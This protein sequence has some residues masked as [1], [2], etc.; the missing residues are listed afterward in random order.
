MCLPEKEGVSA[1][2]ETPSWFIGRGDGYL[3]TPSS[4]PTLVNAAIAL[5]S[6]ADTKRNTEQLI[7]L[8]QCA[9]EA[10]V[11]DISAVVI[12]HRI[13]VGGRDGKSVAM[14]AG[15]RDVDKAALA[16]KIVIGTL[17][18]GGDIVG[19]LYAVVP[20]QLGERVVETAP[21]GEASRREGHNAPVGQGGTHHKRVGFDTGKPQASGQ[22]VAR[23]QVSYAEEW[24]RIARH[25]H[26]KGLEFATQRPRTLLLPNATAMQTK[27]QSKR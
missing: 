22:C 18:G 26:G 13:A 25:R 27:Q 1:R 23:R 12:A 20:P 2:A 4:L 6:V 19:A 16:W 8:A 15:M 10:G 17:V 14:D 3:I 7:I 21:D 11:H 24:H 9:H 5:V